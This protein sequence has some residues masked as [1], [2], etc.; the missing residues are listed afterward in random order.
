MTENE[1]FPGGGLVGLSLSRVSGTIDAEAE[2]SR[3]HLS[4]SNDLTRDY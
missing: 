4:D 2:L 3:P 1:K